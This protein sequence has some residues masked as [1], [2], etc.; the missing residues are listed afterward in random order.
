MM[1]G[2]AYAT[3]AGACP[4]TPG[5]TMYAY[6]RNLVHNPTKYGVIIGET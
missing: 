2:R 5:K 3:Y 6:M 1:C 4:S